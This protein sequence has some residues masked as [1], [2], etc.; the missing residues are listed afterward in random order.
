LCDF[1]GN[2]LVCIFV[3]FFISLGHFGVAL[4]VSFGGFGFFSAPSQDIGREERLQNV[5]FCVKWGVKPC[6]VHPMTSVVYVLLCEQVWY[7][8]LTVQDVITDMT[9]YASEELHLSSVRAVS[10]HAGMLN[11]ARNIRQ[12]LIGR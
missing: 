12:K 7:I 3:C 10:V 5:L 1:V 4:L 9:A 2:E 6:S 11:A 8:M